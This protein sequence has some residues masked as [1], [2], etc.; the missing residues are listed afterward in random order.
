MEMELDAIHELVVEHPCVQACIIEDVTKDDSEVKKDSEK[1]RLI[2]TPPRL[3]RKSLIYKT[4]KLFGKSKAGDR[5]GPKVGR[6]LKEKYKINY[7]SLCFFNE[8]LHQPLVVINNASWIFARLS[9]HRQG[10]A[11]IPKQPN[12]DHFD[13]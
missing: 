7:C 2:Y 11:E 13:Y 12:D 3:F 1:Q 6:S 4:M 5:D 8:L 9:G 10:L